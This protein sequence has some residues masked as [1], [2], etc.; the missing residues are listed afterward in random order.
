MA[1][2]PILKSI[3]R[4]CLIINNFSATEDYEENNMK[5]DITRY[6]LELGGIFS[7]VQVADSNNKSIELTDALE[8]TINLMISQTSKG[9]N[10]ILTLI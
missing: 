6:F 8:K 4:D 2:V 9:M 3:R 1:F 10:T 5:E 7:K